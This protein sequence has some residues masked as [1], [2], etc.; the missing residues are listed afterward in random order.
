M[1][2]IFTF[3]FFSWTLGFPYL[4]FPFLFHKRISFLAYCL[5]F[6]FNSFCG[7]SWL[8]TTSSLSKS[9]S[10][11]LWKQS[12]GWRVGVLFPKEARVSEREGGKR[13]GGCIFML[14][15]QSL[16]SVAGCQIHGNKPLR[17]WISNIIISLGWKGEALTDWISFLF[18]GSPYE[19]L[20]FCRCMSGHLY[21]ID[22]PGEVTE[23]GPIEAEVLWGGCLSEFSQGSGRAGSHSS[24]WN[25]RRLKLI[26][27]PV[28]RALLPVDCWSM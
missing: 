5:L 12:L 18:R 2:K 28:H 6:Y 21:P 25:R 11:F 7:C 22:S 26:T 15:L 27:C 16:L 4:I 20:H 19:V 23:E 10:G 3:K 17:S 24:W 1:I 14:M 13:G 8:M 9:Y